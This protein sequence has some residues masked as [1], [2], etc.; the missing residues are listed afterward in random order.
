MSFLILFVPLLPL[1]HKFVKSRR[2][3]VWL[4]ALRTDGSDLPV[5]QALYFFGLEI[6]VGFSLWALAMIFCSSE[7]NFLISSPIEKLCVEGLISWGLGVLPY[8]G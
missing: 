6:I 4:L 2:S 8:L 1:D 7:P 3:V 5:T